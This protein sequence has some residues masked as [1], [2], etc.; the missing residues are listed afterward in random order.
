MTKLRP[1]CSTG[2]ADT[3]KVMMAEA[4]NHESCMSVFVSDEGKAVELWLDTSLDVYSEWIKG[5]CADIGLMR[6]R[7][8]NRVVGVRLPLLRNNLCVHDDGPIRI[9]TGFRK[10]DCP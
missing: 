9:N 7:K 10:G 4:E 2:F 8:T 1:D 3:L 6:C 5:E